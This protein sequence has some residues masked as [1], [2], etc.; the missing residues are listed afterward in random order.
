MPQASKIQIH[1][2][3]CKKLV[4]VEEEQLIEAFGQVVKK[5]S[6]GHTV[7][8]EYVA[9]RKPD[10]G[11]KLV[12]KECLTEVE[13]IRKHLSSY[14]PN[15]LPTNYDWIEETIVS[16]PSHREPIYARCMNFQQSGVDF[17][18]RSNFNCAVL[19]EMGLGKTCQILTA[20]R[21]NKEKLYPI[22]YVVKG[23]LRLN[24]AA[25]MISKLWLLDGWDGIKDHSELPFILL[26][27]QSAILPGMK[28]VIIGMN[29]LTKYEDAIKKYGFKLLVVDESQNFGNMGSKR[30]KSLLK[31]AA[32]IPHKVCLSGTPILNRATEFFTTL[33]LIKADHWGNYARFVQ[34]WIEI[35]TYYNERGS[36][37]YR[38][39]G[40]WQHLRQAFHEK[41]SKYIIRR[42]KRDVLKDLPKF[43]RRFKVIQ[44][45]SDEMAKTYNKTA[46][47]LEDYLYSNEYLNDKAFDRAN[48]TLAYLVKMR[49]ICGVA[50]VPIIL[51]EVRDFLES[52]GNGNGTDKLLIGCHHNEVMRQLSMGLEEYKPVLLDSGLDNIEREKKIAEFRNGSRVCIAKILAQGEG[53]NLQFCHKMFV[54]EREWNPGKEEQFEARIDRYGQEEPT[55]ATYFIMKN[56]VDETFTQMVEEKRKTVGETLSEDYNFELDPQL[57]RFLAEGAAKMRM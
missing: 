4:Q 16:I 48:K 44:N 9:Q 41:T 15:V 11:S 29:L 39:K 27:G 55:D 51:D 36:R 19:D 33:N 53:L 2:K 26:D 54:C 6:C 7:C 31:I 35:E 10:D 32:G 38:Y 49:H 43:S 52:T 46:Q 47:E 37:C 57:I 14:H 22:L 3:W 24:W 45:E 30:T 20:I 18:E 34:S 23:A 56:T 17:I 13:D 12:C 25:E 5:Y 50:K 42:M 40:I 8:E 21:H 28:N 1:C